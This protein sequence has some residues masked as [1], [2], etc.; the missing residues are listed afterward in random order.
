MKRLIL[1]YVALS[2]GIALFA[3]TDKA[4]RFAFLTDIHVTPDAPSEVA[5]NGIVDEVNT[6]DYAFLMVTGDL[7]N[8]GSDEELQTVKK[9]LDRL[10][11][12][13]YVIPGNHE[14]NWS[15]SAGQTFV[16]L[17]GSDR[18]IFERGDFLFVG[19]ASGPY[20]KMGDGHVKEEDLR[21]L[22]DE[23]Q[24]RNAKAKTLIVAVHY[25][26]KEGLDNWYQVTD[27]LKKYQADVVLCGHEHRLSLHNFDGMA[28]V[29]G[30][31]TVKQASDRDG[32]NC[33]TLRNDSIIIAEK[34]L[35][36]PNKNDFAAFSLR[37]NAAVAGLPTSPLPDFSINDRYPTVD[38]ELFLQDS[39]SI[40]TGVAI[41]E[42]TLVYGNSKGEIVAWNVA[43]KQMRWKKP[44]GGSVYMTPVICNRAV[45][46]GT[47]GGDLYMLDLLSGKEIN[48]LQLNKPITADAAI[49]GHDLFAAAG[50][51]LYKIDAL[52]GKILLKFDGIEGR[53]QGKPLVTATDVIV[54]AWDRH[55]YCLDKSTGQLRWK[56]NNGRS[57][58]LYSPANV[59][60]TASDGK[61]FIVAPDRYMT[62]INLSDGQT[63]WRT[64]RHQ[65]RESM[66]ASEDGKWL[67]AKLMNDSVLCVATEGNEYKEAWVV[68]AGFG[69]EH[70][71]C[72]MVEHDGI[73]YAG[74]R[75]GL[76][77]AIDTKTQ[78]VLF[79][80]KCGNSSIN[81][82]TVL[83]N[84]E[85][86]VS[87]IE[88][89][90]MKIT[91]QQQLP[92]IVGAERTDSYFPLLQGKRVALLSNHTG[93]VKDKHL[94]DV[95]LENKCNVV[96][97]FSP[98]HGFRGDAGAGDH[99]S[100]S[101]D[102]KTGVPIL[103]L[104]DGN[105]GKPS[106]ASMQKFDLLVVDIQDVG[107][108]FYTYYVTMVR[109]MDA[110]AA[111]GKQVIIL[112][113]PNP[114]GHYVDGPILDMKYKS[115]VGWLPIPVVHGMTLGE[116]ALMVNGEKWLPEKRTC[117]LT[118]IPCLNYT[119]QT[120]YRL[121]IPPSPNLPNMLS[122]YLYPSIC[123]FEATPVSLGR[124]TD[125]PFQI[126]GHPNMK[127]YD[128]S[129][130][131]HSMPSATNPPQKDRLCYGVNLSG[132][133]EKAVLEKG[134]DLSYLIDAY[135]NLNMD[136]YF[137]R[138]FFE[139]LIG[140]DYVRKMIK[141]GK[142]ADE[143]KAVWKDDVAKF[144]IQ[145]TPYLLYAE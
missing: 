131:P 94:L 126:Y 85:I 14:T 114:N 27:V 42:N 51:D 76:L 33:V 37:N 2:F 95:L 97:V 26:L 116:L 90:I 20:M 134:I 74:G 23:L 55:L 38:A 7:T 123:Y 142:S 10:T 129:F 89:S 93:M 1:F 32:Y 18:F 45:F 59:V 106:D 140:V 40:F 28:G 104:Y 145:R 15:E 75:N 64:N 71:P 105:T 141:Q 117:K 11:I 67:F 56:W 86:W 57:G 100:S 81:K 135:N 53:L 68:D 8:T 48:K 46:A 62:A 49:D 13:Y 78:Q 69:Y 128:F 102:P 112:D 6:G 127:G 58:V 5:L 19:F 9:A 122:I 52:T 132:A 137:F 111:H 41:S 72:P 144:K 25:P 50:N 29:M 92:V 130:T 119:H 143:I 22:D 115:G 87:L 31:A 16:H 3:Q 54:G 12:P 88:G 39:A 109:M 34:E 118:V 107:L 61:V 24:R 44:C 17:F 47:V 65:V 66:G 84:N 110:C 108:R 120:L 43:D 80:Y 133:S 113:R 60:P 136:D 125:L 30:R 70:N 101:V 82:I 79:K 103:S 91:R 35:G 121:P 99:V 21:W 77:V 124:G 96:A 98:E 4:L 138:S 63:V 139:N 73:V 83:N 36:I